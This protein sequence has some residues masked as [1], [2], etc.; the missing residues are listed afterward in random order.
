MSKQHAAYINL[1]LYEDGNDMLGIAKVSL[2]DIPFKVV[3]VSGAGMGG[4][5]EVPL[6][7]MLENMTMTVNFLS[8]TS[9]AVYLMAPRKHQLDLRVAEENWDVE[10]AEAEIQADKYVVVAMPKNIKPGSVAPATAADASG[11][12][13]V[14]YYAAY[15]D[16]EKLWEI[17]KRALKCEVAGVD[18]AAPLRRALGK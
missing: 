9:S 18:Y 8:V 4:D 5:I 16:G 14:Y 17:D 10:H 7:G 13:A 11:E 2:P 6:I 1:A 3:T 12:F 15:K